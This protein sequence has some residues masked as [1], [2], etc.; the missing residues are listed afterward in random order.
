MPSNPPFLAVAASQQPAQRT[1]SSRWIGLAHRVLF[2]FLALCVIL[3]PHSIKG[4]RHAWMIAFWIWL[5]TLLLERR[6]MFAQP[7]ALPMLAFIAL[8]GLSTAFSPDPYLSWADM[9]LVCY[10]A[11]VGTLFAQNLTRLSQVR[12][13]VFLLVLSAAAAAGFTA[14]QYTFGIGVRI[15]HIDWHTPLYRAG[16]H[17]ND[18]IVRVNGKPVH[19]PDQLR[20]ALDEASPGSLLRINLLRGVPTQRRSLIV[21]I[22][23]GGVGAQS[24]QM[25]RATP[26]RAQGTLGHYGIF[27]EVLMPIGCLA[28]ALFLGSLPQRRW[29]AVIF[30][31]IFLALTAT[32]FATQS[33][34]AMIGL[35]A[36]CVLAPLLLAPRRRRLWAIVI[37]LL[38]AVAANLWIHHSRGLG[39][40]GGSDAGTRY[41]QLMWEDGLRLAL[42]HPL[43]GV[44]MGTVQNH[45]QQWNIRAFAH[46]HVYWNFHSDIVQIAAERGFLTLA[47]WLWFVVAYLVYLLRLLAR[48]RRQN[49]FATVVVAGILSGFVAFLVPSLVESALNDDALVTLLFFC[50]GVAVAVDRILQT[51]GALDVDWRAAP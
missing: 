20:K 50:F 35:L 30:A 26:L 34:A 15:A 1:P 8:S 40:I 49:R 2:A 13:L 33:R 23:V 39:W 36:G 14:W 10:I 42:Q 6:R 29:S 41:R 38:L 18:V 11:L 46:Y 48:A 21:P 9:K 12:T 44:G 27:A 25:A 45:W 31:V 47:A 5:A 22:A 17:T 51:P 24:L 28:W 32:I 7:L 16:I 4:A 37:L 3:L 19:T 43:V